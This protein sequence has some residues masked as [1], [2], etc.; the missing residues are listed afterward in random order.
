MG[1]EAGDLDC[2]FNL[3]I[4]FFL[5]GSYFPFDF[6]DLI[7]EGVFYASEVLVGLQL[8]YCD[9]GVDFFEGRGA[10]VAF[11]FALPR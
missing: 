10:E 3:V 5:G 6:S 4:N 9:L 2:F 8:H 11:L 7:F 1:L